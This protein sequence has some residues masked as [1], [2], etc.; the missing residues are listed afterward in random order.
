MRCVWNSISRSLP[1]SFGGNSARVKLQYL[2]KYSVC[3]NIWNGFNKKTGRVCYET[4]VLGLKHCNCL[5]VIQKQKW[6]W[7]FAQVRGTQRQTWAFQ[8]PLC[9]TQDREVSD[10]FIAIS[11]VGSVALQLVTLPTAVVSLCSLPYKTLALFP[12][13]K[14]SLWQGMY[15]TVK[16]MSALCMFSNSGTKNS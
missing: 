12:V 9:N 16:A 1:V 10:N 8:V 11:S 6:G 7:G 4:E 2:L 3:I 15:V 13:L 5:E 14:L